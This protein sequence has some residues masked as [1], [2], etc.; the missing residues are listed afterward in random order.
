MESIK[1]PQLPVS[2]ESSHFQITW[3][4]CKKLQEIVTHINAS[5]KTTHNIIDANNP[6]G[7]NAKK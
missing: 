7:K 2:F 5:I 6:A 3:S 1:K 4:V